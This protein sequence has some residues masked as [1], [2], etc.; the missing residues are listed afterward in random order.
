MNSPYHRSVLKLISRVISPLEVLAKQCGSERRLLASKLH[1]NTFGLTSDPLTLFACAFSALIHDVD[2]PGVPNSVLIEKNDELAKFY[3]NKSV[4]EQHSVDISWALL[5]EEKYTDLRV[6]II[7]TKAEKDHFRQIVVNCVMATDIM[8]KDLK[9]ARNQRWRRAFSEARV[10]HSLTRETYNRKATIVIELL[11]QAS[12]IAHTMQH[13]SLKIADQRPCIG[14]LTHPLLYALQWHI[15]CKWN[16]RLYKELLSAFLSGRTDSDPSQNWFEGELRFFDF[17][18]IPLAKKLKDCGVFGVSSDE[19][20]NYALSNRQ[21]WESKG[22]EVVCEMKERCTA[23]IIA[24]TVRQS[25]GVPEP[26]LLS[27]KISDQFGPDGLFSTTEWSRARTT[28]SALGP[29]TRPPSPSPDDD[30]VWK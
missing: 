11:I 10:P 22:R 14:M 24:Y 28:V 30:I 4:L 8:D 6:A 15:Y 20:L 2:H 29:E 25:H 26:G 16:E 5:M 21:E 1:D 23:E 3:K 13:V 19:Y 7:S 18:V 27:Y 12:D 17:H 9:E